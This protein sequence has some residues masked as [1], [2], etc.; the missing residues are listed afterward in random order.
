MFTWLTGSVFFC[1]NMLLWWIHMDIINK[2]WINENV[3]ECNWAPLPG[4]DH[5]C[6]RTLWGCWWGS[7]LKSIYSCCPI[8]SDGLTTALEIQEFKELYCHC[9]KHSEVILDTVDIQRIW[10]LRTLAQHLQLEHL[11]NKGF[12]I[13]HLNLHRLFRNVKKASVKF[14]VVN[15][16]VVWKQKCG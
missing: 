7:N 9:T 12:K 11:S 1:T 4:W 16:R 14:M 8:G 15:E 3:T 13:A 6:K 10:K 5:D 2:W